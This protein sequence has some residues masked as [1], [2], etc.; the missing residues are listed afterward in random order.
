M[1]PTTKIN[2]KFREHMHEVHGQDGLRTCWE[3]V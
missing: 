3:R 2:Y 1:T